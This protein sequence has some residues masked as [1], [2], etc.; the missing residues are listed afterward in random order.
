MLL[1]PVITAESTP[2]FLVESDV[3]TP[4]PSPPSSP[5]P[6]PS[7][8]EVST[9]CPSPSPVVVTTTEISV[10]TSVRSETVTSTRTVT[11][12]P[13]PSECPDFS[14]MRSDAQESNLSLSRLR[15]SVT[16]L[17]LCLSVLAVLL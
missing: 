12:T 8:E 5:S 2:A 14:G 11:E 15:I 9:A 6:P 13:Q 7:E 1:T 3:P 4:S 16:S 17:L 10:S